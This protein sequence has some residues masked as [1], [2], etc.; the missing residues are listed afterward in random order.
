MSE[1]EYAAL[2]SALASARIE[3]LEITPQ[4]ERDCRRLM[5]G[6]VSVAEL[7]REIMSRPGQ[8]AV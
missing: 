1:K 3:G 7:V 5:Q 4:N 2:R 8:G 6:D